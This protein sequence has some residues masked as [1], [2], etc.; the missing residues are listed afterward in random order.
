MVPAA[1][2]DHEA[3]AGIVGAHENLGPAD[4]A[5][6]AARYSE[7]LPR[8]ASAGRRR[9][10]SARPE[11]HLRR[12]CRSCPPHSA[13]RSRTAAA[14]R[15]W[16][17]SRC[18]AVAPRDG[19]PWC[20]RPALTRRGLPRATRATPSRTVCRLTPKRRQS[21][22][23]V[24]KRSPTACAAGRD[25]V[26]QRI[27]DAPIERRLNELRVGILVPFGHGTPRMT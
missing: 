13:P 4:R 27:D 26:T 19:P 23:S 6:L 2:A 5:L 1:P 11:R 9:S 20:R 24:G 21:A 25:V 12:R 18:K 10:L 15:C 14:L 3:N 7:S 22:S 8:A 17:S 16:R